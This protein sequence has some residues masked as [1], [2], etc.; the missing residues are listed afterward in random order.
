MSYVQIA[1]AG[2][3]A[4][5]VSLAQGGTVAYWPMV[6]DPA[7]GGTARKVADVSGN[8]YSLDVMLSDAQAVNTTEGAFSRPPNGPS[9][10]T[11]ASC[12]EYTEPDER[13]A[14]SRDGSS[15]RFHD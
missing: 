9:D 4:F 11:S 12:V 8:N 15:P 3:T 13:P 2:L 10:V 5:A 6:M 1:C 14:G 7:T